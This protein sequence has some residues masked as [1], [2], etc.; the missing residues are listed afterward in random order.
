MRR[1]RDAI[2][3]TLVLLAAACAEDIPLL[4]AVVVTAVAVTGI[5]TT[6]KAAPRVRTSESGRMEK[7]MS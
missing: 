5:P 1:Y 4:V 7:P 3:F 2:V 6:R